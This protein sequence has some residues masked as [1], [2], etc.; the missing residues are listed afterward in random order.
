MH[1]LRQ[2]SFYL[3]AFVVVVLDLVL[4]RYPLF[5][6]C[7]TIDVFDPNPEVFGG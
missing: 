7:L 2:F 5:S 3:I 6:D 4:L 1:G